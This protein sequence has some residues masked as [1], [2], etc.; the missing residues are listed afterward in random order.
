MSAIAYGRPVT[1]IVRG[2]PLFVRIGVGVMAVATVFGYIVGASAAE[3]ASSVRLASVVT[4][5]LSGPAM[6]AYAGLL[7]FVVIGCLFAAV[8]A[9]SR[10][11]ARRDG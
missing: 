5:P 1:S 8:E 7:A 4:I 6:A 3:R 9:A 11:E 2:R 10:R